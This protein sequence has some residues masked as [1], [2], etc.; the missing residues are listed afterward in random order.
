MIQWL[1]VMPRLVSQSFPSRATHYARCR[2]TG[3]Q[4]NVVV[5][6]VAW[7]KPMKTTRATMSTEQA[8]LLAMVLRDRKGNCVTALGVE[9]SNLGRR[10]R[11]STTDWRHR[12][13]PSTADPLLFFAE[14]FRRKNMAM[15]VDNARTLKRQVESQTTRCPQQTGHPLHGRPEGANHRQ[16]CS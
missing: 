7:H 2:T 11:R 8:F 12:A 5:Q 1:G 14:V 6:A 10:A 15:D 13:R 3:V 9:L 16:K 4:T